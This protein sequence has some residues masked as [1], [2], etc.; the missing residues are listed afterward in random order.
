M[1]NQEADSGADAKRSHPSEFITLWE[2]NRVGTEEG[3]DLETMY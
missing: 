2:P 1:I 3:S